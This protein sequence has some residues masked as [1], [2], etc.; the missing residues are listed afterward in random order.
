MSLSSL[1]PFE[2]LATEY[3]AQYE[4]RVQECE[5]HTD[6]VFILDE[7]SKRGVIQSVLSASEQQWLSGALKHF[8]IASYFEETVGLSNRYAK[9]K[10]EAGRALV[11]RV[12]IGPSRTLLVGDTAHDREVAAELGVACVLIAHGHHSKQRLEAVHD[13]VVESLAPIAGLA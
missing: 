4:T 11:E 6:T 12:G 13:H 3:C 2:T 1:E 9:G 8:E 5:L 10:I 7:L